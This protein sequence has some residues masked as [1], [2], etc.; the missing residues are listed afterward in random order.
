MTEKEKELQ[1]DITTL[2][3]QVDT[4]TKSLEKLTTKAQSHALTGANYMAKSETK[5]AAKTWSKDE[6]RKKLV[7]KAR[8]NLSP[9]DRHR[10]TK[11]SINLQ[12]TD[13]LKEF[14]ELK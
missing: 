11:F 4:L 7:E 12:L 8:Q 14:L 2:K 6:L 9:D 3:S 1:K 5:P 10:L 13:E